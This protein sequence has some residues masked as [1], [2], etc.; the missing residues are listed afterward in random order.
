MVG[1]IQHFKCFVCCGGEGLW[2]AHF[3]EGAQDESQLVCAKFMG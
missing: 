1:A 3:R 2:V